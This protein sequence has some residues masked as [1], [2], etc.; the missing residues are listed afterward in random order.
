[1]DAENPRTDGRGIPLE[2]ASERTIRYRNKLY[3]RFNHWPIWILVFFITPG[4]L[5]FDLFENGF[6]AQATGQT[7]A[8]G[9]NI[10]NITHFLR[11]VWHQ[12]G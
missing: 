9:P 11:L 12:T 7:A 3:Y 1:M 6:D 4:P 8:D 5:N 2:F 10:G